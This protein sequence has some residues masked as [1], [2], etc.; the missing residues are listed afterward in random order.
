M[1]EGA[2]KKNI[3]RMC[4]R[5]RDA[6]FSGE[7]LQWSWRSGTVTGGQAG[8]AQRTANMGRTMTAVGFGGSARDEH[9]GRQQP[10]RGSD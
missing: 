10:W 9:R 4:D 1:R 3:Q 8:D 7:F 6:R 5:R 2:A